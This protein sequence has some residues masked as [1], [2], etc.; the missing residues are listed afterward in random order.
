MTQLRSDLVGTTP[1]RLDTAVMQAVRVPYSSAWSV[2]NRTARTLNSSSYFFAMM[3]TTFP[4]RDGARGVRDQRDIHGSGLGVLRLHRVR[5]RRDRCG[6]DEEPP[7]GHAHRHFRVAGNLHRAVCRSVARG[8]RDGE[9]HRHQ[10]RSSARRSIPIGRSP[11]FRHGDLDRRSCRIDHG[12]DGSDARSEP[13]LL[14]DEP[15]PVAAGGLRR[16]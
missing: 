7:A 5:H 10:G 8:D 6:G 12:D 4:P 15:G 13:G 1:N 9:V 2:T 16:K 3:R 14:R 11:R